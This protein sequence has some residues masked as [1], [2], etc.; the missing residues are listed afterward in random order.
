[1]CLLRVFQ[2]NK[3]YIDIPLL[4]GTNSNEYLL[5]NNCGEIKFEIINSTL[6]KNAFWKIKSFK[7][8]YVF[9]NC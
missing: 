9:V 2:S 8:D 3:K 7:V 4:R 6:S 1:M 5:E